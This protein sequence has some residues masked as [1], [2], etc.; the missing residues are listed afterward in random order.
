MY[1]YRVMVF[2]L[3]AAGLMGAVAALADMATGGFFDVLAVI[4]FWLA[5]PG[6]GLGLGAG[7]W[8]LYQ[9]ATG[10]ATQKGWFRA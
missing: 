6:L 1:A 8:L 10:E 5:L 3:F 9:G 4:A 2:S 7:G